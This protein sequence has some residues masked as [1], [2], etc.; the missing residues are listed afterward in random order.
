MANSYIA[1]TENEQHDCLL[2]MLLCVML[3]I[4]QHGRE[5][6]AIMNGWF[7]ASFVEKKCWFLFRGVV[8][9]TLATL[10]K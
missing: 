2:R 10:S 3:A 5:L 4:F 1:I 8:L 6:E 9:Y 7:C